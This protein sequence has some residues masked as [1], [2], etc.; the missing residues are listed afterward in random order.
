MLCNYLQAPELLPVS[1]ISSLC[2]SRT[3][4]PE[5]ILV[6]GVVFIATYAT[7]QVISFSK[8][9]LWGCSFF[10]LFYSFFK[11]DKSVVCVQ[12]E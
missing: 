11:N 3:H 12:F 2:L 9:Y 4:F 5:G 6:L 8:T 7:Y 1:V 10:C